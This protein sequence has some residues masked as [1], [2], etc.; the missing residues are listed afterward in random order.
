[1]SVRLHS[2]GTWILIIS[3]AI[4]Y[5][6]WNNAGDK[7]VLEVCDGTETYREVVVADGSGNVGLGTADP[8]P[9]SGK[10]LH[11]EE[12]T[13]GV[14]LRLQGSAARGWFVHVGSG[15]NALEFIP[16]D[17]AGNVAKRFVLDL[18]GNVGIGTAAPTAKLHVVGDI[19]VTGGIR[20]GSS[21]QSCDESI[22]GMMRP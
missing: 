13:S 21:S 20:V 8:T 15:G 22:E 6:R 12:V 11:V 3:P 5:N 17:D 19:T 10:V 4:S 9:F 1:M 18:N 7:K 16:T 2:Y 14:D